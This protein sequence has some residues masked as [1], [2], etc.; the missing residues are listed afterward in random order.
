ME[1]EI[2]DRGGRKWELR[3]FVATS[4]ETQGSG[5]TSSTTTWDSSSTAGM[6]VQSFES[7][8][9]SQRRKMLSTTT[10]VLESLDAAVYVRCK[11]HSLEHIRDDFLCKGWVV[12]LRYTAATMLFRLS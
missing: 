3:F 5:N 10:P 4:R 11:V 6:E 2:E 1:A 12:K 7:G 9:H 8:G